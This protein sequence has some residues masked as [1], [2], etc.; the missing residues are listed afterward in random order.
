MSDLLK[1]SSARHD[2]LCPRQ[3]LGVRIGLAGLA[4]L[5]LDSPV[6]K[7][8]ALIII[9]S[10]GCFAD[11]IEVSTGATIGH[12]TL[13]VNDFGKMAA[14]FADVKTGRVIRISPEL[15][16]RERALLY[17]PDEPRHYFAQLQGYQVMPDTELLRIQEVALNPTL[18]E[19]M[20][21]PLVRVNCDY[22]GEEIINE[23]EVI[24]DGIKLCRTC[25]NEG[26]YLI[27]PG[28]AELRVILNHQSK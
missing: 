6:D 22:C 12:R 10:D 25:A 2:H 5:E 16:V 4:A 15:N 18:E 3:V 24:R 19:L 9:E 14:T 11:G 27:K 7:S 28:S 26:Y 17:A 13:R 20:S 21:K 23:R 8:T 1:Q